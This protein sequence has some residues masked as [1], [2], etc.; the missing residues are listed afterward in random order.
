MQQSSVNSCV[1]LISESVASMSPILYVKSGEGRAEAF[2]NPLHDILC[3]QPNPDCSAF[4]MWDSFVGSIAL[5]GNGYLEITRNGSGTINGLW[6]LHP[7]QT[8]AYRA[9][10]GSLF[11]R[12]TDGLSARESRE[13]P[14]KDVI[15]V[16]WHST[17]GV[18]GMSVIEQN[19]NAIGGAIAMDKHAGRFFA[20][21]ATPSG[22]LTT[23][24][25]VKPEVKLQMRND[26]EEM[27]S[28][29]NQHR[30]A[31]LDQDLKFQQITISNEDSQFLESRNMSRQEIC[32]LFRIN[33]SQIGDTSRVAGE[34]FAA[35]QL[36][37][38]VD[39]LR[40]W[41]N[42]ISQELHRKLLVGL[43]G[44]TIEHD[45]SDRLRVDFKTQMDGFAVARQW[46][47]ATAN[48]VRKELGQNPFPGEEANVLLSPVNMMD[49]K[50]LLLPPAPATQVTLNE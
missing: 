34:T 24:K 10:D 15:H 45:I 20:N 41:L 3:L 30:V 16:P 37:F 19:R 47:F 25:Q 14:A 26:W 49:A 38:L 8:T 33:P 31:V 44:Y 12:T 46:G 6:Y 17:N 4:T 28:G 5:T 18:T 21:N 39:C 2:S 27:Q 7:L 36:T 42:R 50:K 32:G 11:Y 40:P 35:Q 48:E 9:T 22:V 13:L 43:P 29:T 1:R 23:D